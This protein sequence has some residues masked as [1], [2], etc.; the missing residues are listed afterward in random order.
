MHVKLWCCLFLIALNDSIT[1][2][3]FFHWLNVDALV[4]LLSFQ[5]WIFSLNDSASD[6]V[7]S[8]SRQVGFLAKFGL[9]S[10]SVMNASLLAVVS[11]FASKKSYLS[12]AD[13]NYLHS[14][15]V[16]NSC[17]HAATESITA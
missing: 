13:L 2:A 11:T 1:D 12:S 16:M 15:N 17:P 4:I 5:S 10:F 6:L 9:R 7:G 14:I 3:V 8:I